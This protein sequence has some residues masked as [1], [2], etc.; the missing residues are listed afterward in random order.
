MVSIS[1]LRL[2]SLIGLAI[3][4][5][6]SLCIAIP[7]IDF[8]E[9][10]LLNNSSMKIIGSGFSVASN[11]GS[12]I[13]VIDDVPE[14]IALTDGS[15]IPTNVGP[16]TE[17]SPGAYSDEVT[18]SKTGDL[19]T[20][21]GLAVYEGQRR[22]YLGWPRSF[23]SLG[24]KSFYVSWWYNP[25]KLVD[26]GGSN[27][28]IRVWD[29]YSGNGTRVSWTQ[30]HLTY[31]VVD[32]GYSPPTSW[33]ET[34]PVPNQWNH[35]ELFVDDATG[36]LL[37]RLNGVVKHEKSDFKK[38][39]TS[40]G[41]TIGLIGFDPSIGDDYSDLRF[42][43]RDIYASPTQA[44]VELSD[45]PTWEPKAHRELLKIQ[46]WSDTA[47]N[48]EFNFL[49]HNPN[50]D[51]YI[52]VFDRDGNVNNNGFPLCEKCPTPPVGVDIN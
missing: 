30:M 7:K 49:G 11:A 21:N 45:S 2:R 19:R 6:A 34:Q 38:S 42:R 13:E 46:S 47:L 12:Q 25:S 36:T 20:A 50:D 52:Y 22:S 32:L 23:K 5:P 44:R 33:G 51:L 17:N 28:F 18:I 26:K 9:G 10:E 48:V 16:W 43:M 15:P 14:F 1:S 29:D 40:N 27:K 4:F 37:A 3:L 35:F 31:D 41:L 39:P 24:A 8:I